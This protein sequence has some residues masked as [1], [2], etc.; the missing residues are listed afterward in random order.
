MGEQKL[1]DRYHV[2][3]K[4]STEVSNICI[5]KH[6]RKAPGLQK[7]FNNYRFLHKTRHPLLTN[8]IFTSEYDQIV[9]RNNSL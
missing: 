8:T 7:L 2:L 1:Y 3:Y 5:S 9:I 6:I 4:M